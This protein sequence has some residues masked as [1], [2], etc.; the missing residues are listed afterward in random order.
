MIFVDDW[1]A[2]AIYVVVVDQNGLDFWL[3]HCPIHLRL[4]KLNYLFNPR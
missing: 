2:V 1:N 4:H 3:D